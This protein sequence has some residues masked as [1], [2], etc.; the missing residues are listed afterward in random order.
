MTDRER[1]RA[2]YWRDPD[3]ERG[4]K[5]LAYWQAPE[6]GRDRSRSYRRR[7][8]YLENLIGLCNLRAYIRSTGVA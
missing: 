8:R 1:K 2:A 6:R 4:R 7:K 3:K 5:R